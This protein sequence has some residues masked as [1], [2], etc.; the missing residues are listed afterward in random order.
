MAAIL[1]PG[2]PVRVLEAAGGV[3][4]CYAAVVKA[5]EGATVRVARASSGAV[6]VVPPSAI[7]PLYAAGSRV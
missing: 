6:A 1:A 2:E 7:E 3:C 5:V 4:R